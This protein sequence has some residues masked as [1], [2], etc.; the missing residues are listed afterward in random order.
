M[1]NTLSII[2]FVFFI[3]EINGI[4]GSENCNEN[5][6][7]L[8]DKCEPTCDNIFELPCSNGNK[9]TGCFCKVGFI[10]SGTQCISVE[11]C[12]TR[13][14]TRSNTELNFEGRI[15]RCNDD[16]TTRTFTYP[17]GYFPMC[18]CKIG[19]ASKNKICIPESD[20]GNVV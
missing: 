1:S 12:S 16:G 13:I 17:L 15:T 6:V 8:V 11:E 7:Y 20:C 19:Y 2:T 9:F 4:L 14:C 10:R 5:E 18:S 3:Y